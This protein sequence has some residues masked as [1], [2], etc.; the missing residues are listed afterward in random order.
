MSY[1]EDTQI[2][3]GHFELGELLDNGKFRIES[4]SMGQV[5]VPAEHL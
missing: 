1:I 2:K 5:K 4:D 3:D